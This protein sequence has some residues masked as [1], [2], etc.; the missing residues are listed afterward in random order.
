MNENKD[1]QLGEVVESPM[2][3]PVIVTGGNR[4]TFLKNLPKRFLKRPTKKHLIAV[5]GISLA[6]LAIGI[7]ALTLFGPEAPEPNP[8]PT[9][10]SNYVPPAPEPVKFYS[11]LTGIETSEDLSKR[12]VTGVM[13]ENS[14]DARP[15]SALVDAGVVFEAIAEGGITRFLALFQEAQPDYIGPIRS[16]RPYYVR[17]AA[18]FDAAYVHSGGS[19]EALSLIGSLGVKDMDHGK[20]GSRFFDRV[21][22]RYAPHNVYTSMARLDQLR[23]E[24]GYNESKFTPF[25]RI[26]DTNKANA[27]GSPATTISFD[28]SSALYDTSYRYDAEAKVYKRT[29]AGAAHND[30][31]T[32][33]Q[34]S[35]KVVVA[36]YAAYSIHADGVHSVY[37]NIGS[38]KAQFFQDGT[39]VEGTWEKPS[40]KASLV[41][42]TASGAEMPLEPGQVWITAIQEGR[43]TYSP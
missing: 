6:F 15:Q 2:G 25:T 42:K 34:I 10:T 27:A 14:V 30:E 39:V 37:Q 35:P 23:A 24:N 8:V 32:G 29:L 36:L 7:G 1:E 43:V 26:N 9:V 21:S 18:G 3:T 20:Y 5:T 16:A 19:G 22:S 41:F 12:A 40:D 17:W 4:F 33:K 13:I 28:I 38:G 11:P 31:K